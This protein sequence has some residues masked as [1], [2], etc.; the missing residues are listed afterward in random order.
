[1]Y[2]A[3]LE[4]AKKLGVKEVRGGPHSEDAH[5][6]HQKLAQKYG[7]EYTYKTLARPSTVPIATTDGVGYVKQP[8]GRYSYPLGKAEVAW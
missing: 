3:G 2:D 6:V 1:M 7:V 8:Y 4:Y 5:R